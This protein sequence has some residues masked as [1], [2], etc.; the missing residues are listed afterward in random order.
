VLLLFELPV[1]LKVKR[2]TLVNIGK[3]LANHTRKIVTKKKIIKIIRNLTKI[4]KEKVTENLTKNLVIKTKTLN[5]ISVG[6]SV[7]M[8]MTVK[9]KKKFNKLVI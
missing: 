7:I 1:T 6:D 4:Q 3:V 2:R 9:S 8:P 5:V